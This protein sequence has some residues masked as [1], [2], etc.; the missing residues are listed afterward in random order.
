MDAN[1]TKKEGILSADLVKLISGRFR[2]RTNPNGC[3]LISQRDL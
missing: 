1:E 3:L 2:I